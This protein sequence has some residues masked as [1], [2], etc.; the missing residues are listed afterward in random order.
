VRLTKLTD[1]DVIQLSLFDDW[2][3]RDKQPAQLSLF[4]ECERKEKQSEQLMQLV[5]KLNVRYSKDTLRYAAMGTNQ[6]WQTRAQYRSNRWT[7]RW[8]EIPVVKC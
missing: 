5:D 8:E 4:D 6:R 7:T 2:N 3:L 1:E